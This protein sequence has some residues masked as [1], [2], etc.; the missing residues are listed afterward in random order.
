MASAPSG[1]SIVTVEP[2]PT[3]APL[4]TRSGAT[5]CESEPMKQPSSSVVVH[6][7]KPS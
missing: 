1:T 4:P 7:P 5:S 2:V 6:F 3:Y